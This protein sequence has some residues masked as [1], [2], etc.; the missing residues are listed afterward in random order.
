LPTVSKHIEK[1]S[2]DADSRFRFRY[3]TLRAVINRNGEALRIM[4]DLETD[5]NYMRHYDERIKIPVRRLMTEVLLMA[6]ELNLLA[7]DRYSVLHEIVFRLREETERLFARGPESGTHPV[8]LVMGGDTDPDPGLVGGKAAGLWRLSKCF[9]ESVPP[10]FV[11]T[12]EGYRLMLEQGDLARRIRILMTDL[13]VTSDPD[14]FSS[15]TATIRR[16]IREAPVPGKIENEIREHAVRIA[17]GASDTLWAVRS[18]AVCEDGSHSFAGQFESVLQV[19]TDDLVKA[20][21]EVV[22]SRFADRAVSY[23][24]N[25]GCR[26]VDASMAVLFMPMVDA[27]AAGVVYTTDTEKPESGTMLINA[28]PGLADRM[29]R[30]ESQAD[31]FVVARTPEL[32][33]QEVM[34]AGSGK[35]D[36]ISAGKILEIAGMAVKAVE[37]FGHELDMEWAVDRL[38]KVWILQARRLVTA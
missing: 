26:E 25:V 12:T 16:W 24:L 11:I 7:A 10:G 1:E 30:G 15:I 17:S 5:L 37:F 21:K 31:T 34:P 33:V 23:R 20:Y 9:G 29:V 32:R 27:V 2:H 6:Q 13:D 36:Y 4:S 28:V 8:A 22:A 19:E 35:T 3:E 18:S 38:G 14:R